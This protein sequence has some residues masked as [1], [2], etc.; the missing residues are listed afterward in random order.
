MG[1]TPAGCLQKPPAASPKVL[2]KAAWVEGPPAQRASSSC[3]GLATIV[4]ICT[5]QS[6]HVHASEGEDQS[7]C[8]CRLLLQGH[9]I[10]SPLGRA[11]SQVEKCMFQSLILQNKWS[12]DAVCVPVSWEGRYHSTPQGVV[13]TGAACHRVRD[14]IRNTVLLRLPAALPW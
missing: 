14:G 13:K 3:L 10:P 12:R 11:G 2:V 9:Q 7:K 6:Y 4:T 5:M 8:T 1:I